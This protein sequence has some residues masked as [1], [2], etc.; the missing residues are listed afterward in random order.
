ML[1]VAYAKDPL[2]PLDDVL[3]FA[4]DA[5]LS[6]VQ[7][8]WEQIARVL[9]TPRDVKNKRA[10]GLSP[11][12]RSTADAGT[13]SGAWDL[14]P[15]RDCLCNAGVQLVG[16]DATALDCLDDETFD[17]QFNDIRTQLETAAALRAGHF[18][19]TP[20]PRSAANFAYLVAGLKRLTRL[21]EPVGVGCSIRNLRDSSVEQLND[22]HRLFHE[23]GAANLALDLDMAEFQA[24]VVNPH[25]A[26]ISFPGRISRVR[27]CDVNP[28]ATFAALQHDGF[29]G[30]VLAAVAY[31]SP[32]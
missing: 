6:H 19:F 9:S 27:V 7:L 3:R 11:R 12:G 28:E 1:T 24:A 14:A 20:G 4:T 32:G 13:T 22:L 26:A 17:R 23:V 31:E 25:D 10:A 18:T 16:I 15:I 21:A 29:T 30:P 8:A 5:R 2:T